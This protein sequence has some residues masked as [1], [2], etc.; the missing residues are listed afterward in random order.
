MA[1]I[2]SAEQF[3]AKFRT[4]TTELMRKY[5]P[6]RLIKGNKLKKPWIDKKVR[7]L[8]RRR[9]K[10]FQRMR[11]T[12]NET[13]VR[14]YRECKRILQKSERQSYWSYVNNIIEVGDQDSAYQPKQKRFWSYIKSL[15]KDSSGIAPLKDNGR[16][17]NSPTDKA[18][19]LNHQ[20]HSV[21][22]WEDPSSATPDPDGTPLPD[23]DNI[24]VTEQGVKKLL[25]KSNPQKATGPDMIPAQILRECS[26]ELAPILTIVFNRTLQTGCVPEDWKQ[27][28]VSA[29]FKKGQRYD[30][31]NYRPVS[32]TCLC[33]KMLEHIITSSIMKH[34]DHHQILSDCQHGFR[35]RR[36]CE[37]QLVTLIN[38]LSSSLDRGDQ[39]DMVILDFSKAFDRVPHKRLLR[40][41]HHY[42]IR[43]HLHSWITSFLTGRSQKVIVEGSESESAPVIS[44]VPQGS[45]LSPLLFLLFINDLPDNIASNTRLFA[46]DC[47][48]YRTIRYHADQEALQEDLVRLAEWEDKWGMEFHP[49][50]CSTLSVTRSRS[51]PQISLSAK[52][53]HS[54]GSRHHQV[55]GRRSPVNAV[56]EKPHRPDHKEIEQHARILASKLKVYQR[57]NQDKCLY[58]HGQAKP[59]ILCIGVEPQPERANTK[60]RDDPTQGCKICFQPLQKHQQRIIDAWCSP[61]GTTRIQEDKNPAYPT[62]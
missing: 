30:P 17:F 22:T 44:G 26:E 9:Q 8:I 37:T 13:D 55:P 35:A 16:L 32:L 29:V 47:I 33:C 54:W 31:A 60:D 25:Q 56:M 28:N 45:V 53:T 18:N 48:V 2:S 50:K 27:A 57:R 51:P 61:M 58:Q 43:G 10:L 39:T 24:T 40:K 38:D 46:D 36:S 19:I 21:F 12:R 4:L 6:T 7:S 62:V 5:I 41:L 1:E 3:W 59:G 49:Q 14:K 34:V 11:K 42:G 52:R 15:R 20:Y 23:M